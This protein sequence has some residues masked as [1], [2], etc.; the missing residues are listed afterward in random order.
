[1]IAVVFGYIVLSKGLIIMNYEAYDG[2][3]YPVGIG[4]LTQ[5]IHIKNWIIYIVIQDP[6][7]PLNYIMNR[8][9]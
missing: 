2:K 7:H 1:M 8:T 5:V 3:R 6:L 4:F 9:S